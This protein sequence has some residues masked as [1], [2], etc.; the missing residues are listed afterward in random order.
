MNR[1]VIL[2]AGGIGKRMRNDTP[3]Q[4][5]LLK[6]KPVLLHTLQT[7][8]AALPNAQ[9]II[10]LPEAHQLQ[11][12]KICEQHQVLINHTIVIGGEERFFSV[13]NALQTIQ[14]NKG[15]VLIH[16]GVRPLVSKHT[17]FATLNL[18]E[19]KGSAVPAVSLNDSIRQ[20]NKESSIHL[21]RK[22][23]RLVQTPQCFH[24]SI[25]KKAY[26]LPYNSLFTDDA[27]VV[28][29][30]GTE[31]FLS[32]GNTENI[33]LTTPADLLFAEALLADE[34]RI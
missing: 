21:D 7:F 27:S 29:A 31:I 10:V 28:E 33:K 11:W 30:M 1:F 14:E 20:V 15:M 25:I 26:S 3:K 12:K 8:Y 24:T 6:E 13:K 2:V 5:L 16:D 23:Y 9:Y 22:N 34:T 4:F 18:A 19:Q 17:I 32:E